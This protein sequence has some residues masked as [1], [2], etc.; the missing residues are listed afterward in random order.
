V[1]AL[2]ELFGPGA[3]DYRQLS[4]RVVTPLG[5]EGGSA[6]VETQ[7]ALDQPGRYRL[8]A[9]TTDLAGRSTVVWNEI[10]VGR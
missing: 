2:W 1:L 5:R 8:R 9:A 7:F 3:E 4:G 10:K 6:V